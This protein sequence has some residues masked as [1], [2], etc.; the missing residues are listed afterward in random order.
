MVSF[1]H[2]T[3]VVP[4]PD[5]IPVRVS[6]FSSR[7]RRLNLALLPYSI[8]RTKLDREWTKLEENLEQTTWGRSVHVRWHQTP[9]QTITPTH[10]MLWPARWTST[11]LVHIRL[12]RQAVPP[13]G[14]PSRC[15]RQPTH[16]LRSRSGCHY[17]PNP[18][19]RPYRYR[20]LRR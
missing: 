18:S 2:E 9:S 6:D 13:N 15:Y 14:R 12:L 3:G 10:A 16:H 19:C 5:C 4:F 8:N 1:R 17:L 11:N 7:P 20:W